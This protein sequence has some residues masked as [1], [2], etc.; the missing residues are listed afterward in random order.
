MVPVKRREEADF[1]GG[2][3]GKQ[4]QSPLS[5]IVALIENRSRQRRICRALMPMISTLYHHVI[6]LATD[7]KMVSCPFIA[8]SLAAFK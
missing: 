8:R 4:R 5:S 3:A 1:K 2:R 6:P 7:R